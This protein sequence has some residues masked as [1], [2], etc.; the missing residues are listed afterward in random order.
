MRALGQHVAVAKAMVVAT[1]GRGYSSNANYSN[2]DG[3][4]A[5]EFDHDSC[6]GSEC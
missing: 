6:S 3:S 4:Y 1:A 2:D 5:D